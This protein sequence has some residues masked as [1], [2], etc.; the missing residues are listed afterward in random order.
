MPLSFAGA[1]L[2]VWLSLLKKVYAVGNRP[3][4][5]E[6]GPLT[7]DPL[8]LTAKKEKNYR[9]IPLV[10]Q[11]KSKHDI[12]GIRLDCGSEVFQEYGLEYLDPLAGFEK[13]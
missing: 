2:S 1:A 4:A 8:S 12:C 11:G 13:P 6:A 5:G 7:S 10:G 9:K 3:N